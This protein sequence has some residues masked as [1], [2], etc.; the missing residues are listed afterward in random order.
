MR[1]PAIHV[2]QHTFLSDYFCGIAEHGRAFDVIPMTVAVYNVP[3]RHTGKPL[4]ELVLH[5]PGKIS[6]DRVRNKDAVRRD[7]NQAVPRTI[8]RAIQIVRKLDDLPRRAAL[9]SRPC[10]RDADKDRENETP[11]PQ[12]HCG[13]H[14]VQMVVNYISSQITPI[15]VRTR[16]SHGLKKLLVNVGL[17]DIPFLSKE[18][19]AKPGFEL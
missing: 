9:S 4:I 11:K 10:S 17:S 1:V 13:T 7:I 16:S 3:N 12:S 18:T 8:P 14:H 15:T 5:P 2:P 6:A 19:F